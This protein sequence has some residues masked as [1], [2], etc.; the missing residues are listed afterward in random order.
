[1]SKNKKIAIGILLLFMLLLPLII[2][3]YILQIVIMT[4][5]SAVLGL[6]F[7]LSLKVGLP[8]FDIA[9]WMGVGAYTSALLMTKAGMS[10]WPTVVIGGLISVILGWMIYII[11]MR[12]GMIT[13]FI[14]TMIMSMALFQLFGSLDILGG[15]TG[16]GV[17]ATP[18]L[19]PLKFEGKFSIYYL[20]LFFIVLVIVV[21]NLLYKSKIGRAWNAI[22]SSPKLA[23]SVGVNVIKYRMANVL[24]GNFIISMVGSYFIVYA[25][26]AVPTAFSFALS[27]Q[28]MMYVVVGGMFYSVAGP[29]IGATIIAFLPEYLRI[30]DQYASILTSAVIIL[31]VI[32]MPMGILGLFNMRIIPWFYRTKLYA[33]IKAKLA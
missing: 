33:R 29:I 1:M 11:P 13:F 10:F 28:M 9:G 8:R 2:N 21:L 7:M 30:A 4:I 20:G 31:I 17:V 18:T 16:T 22:G 23:S 19:G 3:Q 14:F 15:W 32:F 27:I 24:I 26:A 12:R 5:A 6:T 25:R